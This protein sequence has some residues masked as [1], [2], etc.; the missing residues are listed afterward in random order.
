MKAEQHSITSAMRHIASVEYTN[1]LLTYFS[2]RTCLIAHE[3]R[4]PV[5]TK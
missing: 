1:K 3:L 5:N 2:H 4:L